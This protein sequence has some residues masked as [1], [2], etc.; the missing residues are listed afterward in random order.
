[1]S[2]LITSYKGHLRN[3]L[4]AWQVIWTL[5]EVRRETQATFLVATVILG[6]LR[7]LKKSGIVTF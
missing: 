7:I 3:L 4:E 1:M 6:F 2:R 5:L